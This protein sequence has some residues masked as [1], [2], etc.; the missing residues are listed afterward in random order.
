MPKIPKIFLIPVF[1]SA[2]IVFRNF[3]GLAKC[4]NSVKS[5]KILQK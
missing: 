3:E 2:F 5:N 4:S 1:T